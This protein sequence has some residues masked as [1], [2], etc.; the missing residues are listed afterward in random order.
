[1]GRVK[2]SAGGS[3]AAL[4]KQSLLASIVEASEDAIVTATPE[5]AI[6]SWN[7]GAE[8]L[9]GYTADEAVGKSMDMLIP[10]YRVGI[11]REVAFG[12]VLQGERL[13]PYTAVGL[14]KD[15]TRFPISVSAVPIKGPKGKV[16]AGAAIIRDISARK[17]AEQAMASL[18]SIVE[19]AEDAIF[20]TTLGGT[21]L[22]WNR[23]AEGLFG[24]PAAEMI[25]KNVSVLASP[26]H[27]PEQREV[28][29]R[30]RGGETVAQLETQIV[31]V[32]GS[33]VDVSISVSPVTNAAGKVVR[34]STI[35]RDI[36]SRKQAEEALRQSEERYR[37]LFTCHPHPMWVYDCETYRFLAVNEAAVAQYGRARWSTFFS[38]TKNH[39]FW[40]S[41][42]SCQERF[43]R[44]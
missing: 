14:R 37:L 39:S 13:A 41:R 34:C 32:D 17:D 33:L 2:I 31:K 21:I 28:L 22:T 24:Y 5:G 38:K 10:A 23:G 9:Y 16:T 30:I 11:F 42:G 26:D 25:E 44:S 36:S 7:R 35:A 3:R 19:S 29:D 12:K 4:D 1:M 8:V 40:A 18:A 43:R 27:F 6:K 20:S 15:G